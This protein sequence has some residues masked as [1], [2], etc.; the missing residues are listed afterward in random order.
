MCA[1]PN[2]AVVCRSLI[3]CFPGMLVGYCLNDFVMVPFALIITDTTFAYYYYYQHQISYFSA[4]A[5]KY[6]PL[7][8]CSNKQD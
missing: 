1:V 3:A 4:L 8:G 2:T 5:G 6:S 7:L